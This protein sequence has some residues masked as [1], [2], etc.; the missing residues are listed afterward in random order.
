MS[1]EIKIGI[2]TEYDG[3]G[4][5]KA[6]K[7]EED[8]KRGA[9]PTPQQTK[10]RAQ[11]AEEL[12][13]KELREQGHKKEADALEKNI[14]IRKRAAVLES[15]LGHDKATALRLAEREY[16]LSKAQH[17]H[18][19]MSGGRMFG[20]AM[21]AV[22][23]QS[24]WVMR[25]QQLGNLMHIFR[26]APMLTGIGAIAA[27]TVGVL[28]L[29]KN[30]EAKDQ[31][32]RHRVTQGRLDTELKAARSGRFGNSEEAFGREL[33]AADDR[34]RNQEKRAALV[35]KAHSGISG[36]L[37][38]GFFEKG[39]RFFKPEIARQIEAADHDDQLLA[40][41]QRKAQVEKRAWFE[42]IGKREI[43]M[44]KAQAA[45]DMA[46]ARSIQDQLTATE[47]YR[48]LDK[49]GASPDEIKEG[50][51]AK[52]Q[53]VQ[54]D[55]AGQ[56]ARLVTARDGVADTAAVAREAMNLRNGWSAGDTGRIVSTM[57][58]HHSEAMGTATHHD[59]TR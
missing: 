17:A 16:A 26:A 33:D 55:R 6:K 25:T 7:D 5:Q 32:E 13:V 34:K 57:E 12:Q 15:T 20:D 18:Q 19:K 11:Y 4:A 58:K 2:K 1:E 45:G 38:G 31:E 51:T 23:G 37:F 50:I 9:T 59:F 49:E 30:E 39:N 56:L 44:T 43:A 10:A 8:L 21:D 3:A 54:R 46:T 29:Q 28:A 47:E 35:D 41:E 27:A 42:K 14:T 36:A 22:T 52:M 53:L 24:G 40:D 48:K